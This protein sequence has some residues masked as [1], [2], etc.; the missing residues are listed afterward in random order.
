[1]PDHSM[2]NGINFLIIV[3]GEE[4]FQDEPD[5]CWALSKPADIPGKPVRPVTDKVPH[6]VSLICQP[7]L[8]CHIDSV[9]HLKLIFI[10]R[11]S[12]AFCRLLYFRMKQGIVG[13]NP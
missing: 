5:V 2:S 12:S 9:Q 10:S 1:M 11:Q 4:I 13:R 7:V 6:G 3:S 8:F